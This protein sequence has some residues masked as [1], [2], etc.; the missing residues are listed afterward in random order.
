M[1]AFCGWASQRNPHPRHA[2][3]AMLVGWGTDREGKGQ[4]AVL[5]LM[6]IVTKGLGFRV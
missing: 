2:Q 1:K 3:S 6:R 4:G 5:E